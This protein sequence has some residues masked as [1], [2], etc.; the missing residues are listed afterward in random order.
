MF[1]TICNK[2]YL[3][4]FKIKTFG[5]HFNKRRISVVFYGS[6]DFSLETV[7]LLQ[8]NLSQ[9]ETDE[10]LI[11]R[12]D[13]VLSSKSNIISRFAVENNLTTHDFPYEIPKGLYDVGVVSSFGHLIPKR[14]ISSCRLGQYFTTKTPFN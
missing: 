10:K 14:A 13:L 5:E 3:R 2:C 6:D 8:Q 12:L 1:F 9:T 4:L 11:K 7:R